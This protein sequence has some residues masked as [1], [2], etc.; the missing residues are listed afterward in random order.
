MELNTDGSVAAWV[1]TSESASQLEKLPISGLG[2]GCKGAVL[3]NTLFL[4]VV[5]T[6]T[7]TNSME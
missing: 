3:Q 5:H 4:K 1:G 7:K 2:T 6:F